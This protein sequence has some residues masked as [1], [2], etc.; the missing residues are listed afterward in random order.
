MKGMGNGNFIKEGIKSELI[1]KQ[2]KNINKLK[3]W[4]FK[5]KVGKK[6]Y[7]IKGDGNTFQLESV[8]EIVLFLILSKYVNKGLEKTLDNAIID[9]LKEGI[10]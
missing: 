10:E 1:N 4:E 5:L 3:S 2:K 8:D 7:C 6:E 9:M